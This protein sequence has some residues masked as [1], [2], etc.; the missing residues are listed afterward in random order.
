[1]FG[2]M[3]LLLYD[4]CCHPCDRLLHGIFQKITDLLDLGF[5]F[6]DGGVFQNPTDNLGIFLCLARNLPGVV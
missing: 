4:A 5:K 2:Q 6:I 3:L 1:M